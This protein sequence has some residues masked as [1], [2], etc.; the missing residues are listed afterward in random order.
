MS[1]HFVFFRMPP[2][3]PRKS[4]GL[5]ARQVHQRTVSL[6]DNVD[7][8]IVSPDTHVAP[9]AMD[10][11]IVTAMTVLAD[12]VNSMQN[13]MGKM[14][15]TVQSQPRTQPL[16]FLGTA[17][18]EVNLLN[19]LKQF[20]CDNAINLNKYQIVPE[21]VLH[22]CAEK[23]QL[24]HTLPLGAGVSEG[25]KRKI[26]DDEYVEF[27]GLLPE[28]P[29]KQRTRSLPVVLESIKNPVLGI[30]ETPK[31]VKSLEDWISA[32]AIYAAIYIEKHPSAMAG[33]LKYMEVLRDLAR[34]NGDW[35]TD[36]TKFRKM[37]MQF[38]AYPPLPR[39]ETLM[40]NC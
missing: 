40:Y 37:Q 21:H 35:V 29:D 22:E 14:L 28:Q 13:K 25:V 8:V 11:K 6:P 15:Q 2:V 5:K 33:L 32:F 19:E 36:D 20:V 23:Y 3:R 34:S 30:Q 27:A 18:N 4:R 31:S 24:H 9:L 12:S 17:N 16:S 1:L 10:I 7:N 38:F 39:D 26:W